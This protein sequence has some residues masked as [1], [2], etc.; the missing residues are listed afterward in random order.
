[1]IR[2]DFVSNSSSSSFMLIGYCFDQLELR[3]LMCEKL[4]IEEND[5]LDTWD[6]FDKLNDFDLSWCRGLET[7]GDTNICVGRAYSDMKPYETKE[8]FEQNI[9]RKINEATG[10][11][12]QTITVMVDSGY[13]G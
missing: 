5:D 7:Y 2:Y 10:S 6:L 3:H 1:M 13:D 12:I 8:H 4:N 11:N 9:I